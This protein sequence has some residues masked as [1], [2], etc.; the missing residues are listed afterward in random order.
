MTDPAEE[1]TVAIVDRKF[2]RRRR[3]QRLRRFR[4]LLAV[5]LALVL[6]VTGI[7]LIFFSSVLAVRGVSVSGNTTIPTARIVAV[8]QAP[9]GRPLARADLGAIQARVEA[10]P[11]IASASVSRSWPHTIHIDV[12]ER[13]PLAV[14]NRGSGFQDVDVDGVLFGH[15]AQQPPNLPLIKTNDPGV[16]A[17]ALAEAARVVASL[18]SDIATRVRYVEVKTVDQIQLDLADGRTVLWGSA[19]QSSQ[20]AEVLAVLLQGKAR[21]IDVSVP[22]RPTTKG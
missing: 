6:L 10:L 19:E 8:A 12:V 22:E 16:S 9:I 2:T 17:E 20:K 4:P 18:R 11:A 21:Q 7:W 15:F 1:P 5:L 13:T 14:V 3:F